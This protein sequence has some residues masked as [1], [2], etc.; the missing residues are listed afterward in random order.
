MAGLGETISGRQPSWTG[1]NN[2]GVD[3]L[4]CTL[5]ADFA[6]WKRTVEG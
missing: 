1:A 6:T 5:H 4:H 3:R 2:Q